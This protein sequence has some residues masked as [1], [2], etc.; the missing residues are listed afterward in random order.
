MRVTYLNVWMIFFVC[1]QVIGTE[2]DAALKF[3]LSSGNSRSGLDSNKDPVKNL[4]DLYKR[5]FKKNT[6]SI[7]DDKPRLASFNETLN[8]IADQYRQGDKTF[9]L[10]LNEFADWTSGELDQLRGVHV[11]DDERTP[12][13]TKSDDRPARWEGKV[14]MSK[15]ES[16]TPSTSYDFT[17]RV[18]SG[19]NVPVVSH[20]D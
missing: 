14:F 8:A 16:S 10:E 13:D 11:P 18:V 2:L 15:A 12:I 1:R 5:E 3:F 7:G 17:S 6:K 4:Y 19:T 9:S 20:I